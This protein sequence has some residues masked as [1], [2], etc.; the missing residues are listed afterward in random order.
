MIGTSCHVVAPMQTSAGRMGR[1]NLP[2]YTLTPKKTRVPEGDP[3]GRVSVGVKNAKTLPAH[4]NGTRPHRT[5]DAAANRARLREET[6]TST[7]P[8]KKRPCCA[9]TARHTRTFVRRRTLRGSPVSAGRL[10]AAAMT[11]PQLTPNPLPDEDDAETP[12][13]PP[14]SD[15]DDAPTPKKED[16]APAKTIRR[17]KRA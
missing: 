13:T 5:Q 17:A 9:H 4:P 6:A 7:L 2:P 8:P 15:A 1:G 16:A 3:R 11:P 14:A 12:Q 10:G